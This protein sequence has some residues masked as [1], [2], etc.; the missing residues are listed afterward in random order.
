MQEA[1]QILDLYL[2]NQISILKKCTGG[3]TKGRQLAIITGRG[4][5]SPKGIARIKPVVVRRLQ[6]RQLV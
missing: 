6:E 5:H 2:D 3:Y 4:K 1:I